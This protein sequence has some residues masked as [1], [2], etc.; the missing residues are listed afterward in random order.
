MNNQ[1]EIENAQLK[2]ENERLKKKI[3]IM[4]QIIDLSTDNAGSAVGGFLAGMRIPELKRKL[5]TI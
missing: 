4:S 2:A 1:L 5:L 3:E